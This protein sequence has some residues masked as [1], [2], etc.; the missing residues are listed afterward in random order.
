MNTV[1]VLLPVHDRKQVTLDFLRCLKAQTYP[2]IRLMLIDDGSADGTQEAVRADY[3]SV[4]VIQGDGTWWWAG[5]LQR[6]LDRLKQK[7]TQDS[8]II[9]FAN[10]DTAFAADFVE[11]AVKYLADKPGCMLLSRLRNPATGEIREAGVRADLR[12][13]TFQVASDPLTI[14]CLPTRGLF[15]RWGDIKRAGDFRPLLL[16]HYL[17]D[18]EYTIRAIRKGLKGVTTESV[19]LEP[20]LA[21]TASRDFG[22]LT[23]WRFVRELVSPKCPINPVYRSS[24]VILACPARWIVR[25]LALI[26]WQATKL[27]VRQ[28]LPRA[29]RAALRKGNR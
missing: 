7:A 24:F 14:N 4:E 13:M 9:L 19:W 1:H 15:M 28:A 8:D 29:V 16:P 11:R 5:C 12:E 3:P 21:L 22:S 6:G 23:G 10:D 26:W 25:N 20:N 2:S 17:S 27:I 18:Y